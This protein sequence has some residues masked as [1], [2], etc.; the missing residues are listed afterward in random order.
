MSR[1]LYSQLLRV[2]L[3][4]AMLGFLWR[5]WRSPAYRGSLRERL[6][7]SLQPR[8]D[9][10]MWLHAA[11]VG[12]VRALAALLR[13]LH[14]D[15][16]PLLVTVGTP[17]GLARAR[18]MFA[19]LC[20]PATGTQAITLQ[21]APWDLPGSVRRFLRAV[22]PRVA[23]FIETELW[24]NLVAGACRTGVPLVLVS[25]RLSARSLGR[26]RRFAP[27]LMCDT[28][29]AFTTI[30]AQSEADRARF[31]E[32]GADAT[33][34]SVIGNLKFDLPT[35][36][37][38]A[39]RGA[40]LR[41]RWAPQRSLWVA[42]ST[43]P[44]EEAQCIAAHHELL[45]RARAAG[46]A[47]PLLALAPRRP[48]RFA[49]VAHWLAAQGLQVARSSQHADAVAEIVLI[50]EMGVLTDWYAA[51]DVAF[52]GG[53]LVPVGGHNLLEPAALGKPVIAGPHGFSAPEV[54]QRLIEAGG[55]QVVTN[56]EQLAETLAALLEGSTLARERGALAAAAVAAS[57]GAATR[58]RALIAAL[59]AAAD[60]M[61]S[62]GPPSASG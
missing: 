19:D 56:A 1:W 32:L 55:L 46:L 14:A 58:A 15:A 2:A 22:R 43:H 59:P 17:T 37:N 34:V 44:G 21:A 27:Q 29:R 5:R 18:E 8:I 30:G 38:Q 24:P 42:G 28:V 13:A 48:E 9:R 7:W 33:A 61:A 40:A 12:E 57:R 11:S 35:D 26:Y 49:A 52:V 23:V 53:S 47:L 31:I 54:A 16:T 20:N 10:P 41:A 36:I 60:L 51:G 50:D 25:A 4:F 39:E 6:G 3:P 45:Q 62:R